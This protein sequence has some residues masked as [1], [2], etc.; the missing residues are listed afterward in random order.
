MAAIG[1]RLRVKEDQQ[2]AVELVD[3]AEEPPVHAAYVGRRR[4]N[5]LAAGGHDVGDPVDQKP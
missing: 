1:N 2:L 3:F 4:F 5:L